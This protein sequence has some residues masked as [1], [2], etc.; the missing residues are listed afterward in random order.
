[1]KKIVYIL[2]TLA[3]LAVVVFLLKRNKETAQSKIYHYNKELPVNVQADTLKLQ[4]V[5]AKQYFT[6]SFEPE[7]EVKLGA[8]TQGKIESIFVDLGSYVRKGQP[9]IKID[10][11]LLKLQLQSVSI[12]IEGLET[13]VK[14]YTILTHADAI[15]GVQLEKAQLGLKSAKVQRNNILEQISKTKVTAPFS[16]IVTMKFAEVGAFAAPG[17]PLLQVTDISRLRFTVSVPENDLH[18]FTLSQNYPVTADAYSDLDFAGKAILIGSKGNQANSFPVQFLI[19]NSPDLKIK[20]G[21]FGKVLVTGTHTND[22]LVI[23]ASAIVGSDI[24]PKVYLVKNNKAILQSISISQRLAN[25]I[26]IKDGVKAGDII[27]TGGFINLYDGAFVSI[28]N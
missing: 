28:T 8:E 18:L 10:D 4:P 13:D 15:Q 23:P 11:A 5:D 25:D 16:G 20:S 3:I 21:M 14:R 12:Q 1:M 7:K 26:V 19:N 22:G 6:G 9:L 2:V 27:V 24:E 17:M